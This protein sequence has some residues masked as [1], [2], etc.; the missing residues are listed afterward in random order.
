M[1][2]EVDWVWAEGPVGG[3]VQWLAMAAFEKVEVVWTRFGELTDCDDDAIVIR[4][5]PQALVE[6]P[7]GVFAEGD[8]VAR[9]VVP[10]I[11]ELVDVGGVNNASGVD[12]G[13]AVAGERTGIVIGGDHTDAESSFAPGEPR[14]F[15]RFVS[16]VLLDFPGGWLGKANHLV[17]GD[18]LRGA[19]IFR[20]QQ[21]A[22]G[23]AAGGI[24]QEGDEV[25]RKLRESG[26]RFAG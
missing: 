16:A 18:L 1:P 12:G 15:G 21:V 20:N 3:Q 6:H 19:E 10:A 2:G 24:L 25:A 26:D 17:Q 9:V 5:G 8:A 14:L 23:F 7:V 22:S 11:A 4:D 13:E